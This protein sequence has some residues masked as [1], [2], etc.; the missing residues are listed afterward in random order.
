MQSNFTMLWYLHKPCF[1]F[2][3]N[4]RSRHLLAPINVKDSLE[5]NVLQLSTCC[6]RSLIAEFVRGVGDVLITGEWQTKANG[7]Q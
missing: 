6:C 2:A 7:I 1:C 3:F 5:Y 4:M